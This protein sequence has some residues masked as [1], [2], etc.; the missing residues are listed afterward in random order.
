MRLKLRDMV[1]D[2]DNIFESRYLFI[3]TIIQFKFNG[4]LTMIMIRTR[5]LYSVSK[6]Y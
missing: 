5:V 4:L 2:Y 6:E 1:E 3:S